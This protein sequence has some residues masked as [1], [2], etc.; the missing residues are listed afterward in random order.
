MLAFSAYHIAALCPEQ[1]LHEIAA[2]WHYSLALESYRQAIDEESVDADAL[3][4]CC[5]LLTLLSF[6]HLSSDLSN[7]DNPKSQKSPA[8]DTV[9]LRFIGG[10]RILAD[11]FARRSMLDQG[12]WQPLIRHCEDRFFKN[13]G[14]FAGS[15]H[16][17][18][19]MAGLEA[20]CCSDEIRGPFDTALQSIRLLMQCYSSDRPKMVEFT[21][22]FA[23]KLDP[24]FL[25]L[26]EERV[27]NALLVLCYWY[28]LVIQVDQWW[29]C[30]TAQIEGLKLLRYL[31]D[32]A[33]IAIQPLLD[34]P[35]QL[36]NVQSSTSQTHIII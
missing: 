31:Q 10:P 36:L 7:D 16:A 25:R 22:C 2:A 20:V 12:L 5:M 14:M 13:D 24:R 27:P 9:G 17:S 33:N 6:K 1:R 18:Q 29:A 35:A 15:S 30:R 19:S 3:F 34:F 26:A 11:A 32:T 28:A 4:A 21:F 23:I 8:F